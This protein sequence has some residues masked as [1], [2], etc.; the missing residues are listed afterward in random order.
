MPCGEGGGSPAQLPTN[1]FR[2][3]VVMM[4]ERD[5]AS[6]SPRPLVTWLLLVLAC[7]VGGSSRAATTTYS[8]AWGGG[9]IMPG[10]AVVLLDGASL[11]G[12]VVAN[13]L[14]EFGQTGQI[15]PGGII[16]GTG[17]FAITAGGT[18]F[19][20]KPSAPGVVALELAASIPFGRMAVQNTWPLDL[21]VG[22]SGT[23]SLTI[24]NG[25]VDSAA[26]VVGSAA[27]ASGSVGLTGG[28]WECSDALTIGGSGRG[29]LTID[30]GTVVTRLGYV[31]RDA[32]GLGTISISSG[33]LRSG[34]VIG[35]GDIVI[36]EAG[37]GTLRLS[38]GRIEDGTGFLGRLA[39]GRGTAVITGGTWANFT[40]LGIG[41]WGAAEMSI[42]GGV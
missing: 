30:G 36:G 21:Y 9:T 15:N 28:W 18:V 40:N 13:G 6:V 41:M 14:L 37:T 16:S 31:G 1:V 12:P 3:E 29:E 34:A 10:D 42:D 20:S 5:R 11:T 33:T 22:S 26:G 7:V 35:R 19:L 27:L 39:G 23:G 38:G 8:S 25:G 4:A 2:A 32:G 17:G 24:A